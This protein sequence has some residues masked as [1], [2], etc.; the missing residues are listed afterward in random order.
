MAI[1]SILAVNLGVSLEGVQ[2]NCGIYILALFLAKVAFFWAFFWGYVMVGTMYYIGET[3]CPGMDDDD[4]CAPQGPMFLFLL[5]SFYWT[6]QVIMVST[7]G[8]DVY[9]YV[10]ALV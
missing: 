7:N 10:Q 9:K 8:A 3:M 6:S 5:L 2:S 1:D 4:D